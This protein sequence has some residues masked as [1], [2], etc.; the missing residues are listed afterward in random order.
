MCHFRGTLLDPILTESTKTAIEGFLEVI[1]TYLRLKTGF[2]LQ[3][4]S[5]LQYNGGAI[6]YQLPSTVTF[7]PDGSL[8]PQ[9]QILLAAL[10]AQVSA[11][12]PAP[13]GQA[14]GTPLVLLNARQRA[15]H[16]FKATSLSVPVSA[17]L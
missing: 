17:A 13:A 8:H 5:G 16:P 15:G 3:V 6:S 2:W 11:I 14:L 10:A 4:L 9:A 12:E 7:N 1:C